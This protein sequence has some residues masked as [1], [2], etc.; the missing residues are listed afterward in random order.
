MFH[1]LVYQEVNDILKF[2]AWVLIKCHAIVLFHHCDLFGIAKKKLFSVVLSYNSL[3]YTK[4]ICST[5]EL[6]L[7][8]S[9][10]ISDA[11]LRFEQYFPIIPNDLK[12]CYFGKKIFLVYRILKRAHENLKIFDLILFFHSTSLIHLVFLKT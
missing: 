5:V 10:S 4:T 3:I 9:L 1:G 6:R 8:T 11:A 7:Q 2:S 12:Y